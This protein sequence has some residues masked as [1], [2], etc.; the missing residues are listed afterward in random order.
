MRIVNTSN[1]D[2]TAKIC[3][4]IRRRYNNMPVIPAT[5]P[6]PAAPAVPRPIDVMNNFNLD[7][8]RDPTY[9]PSDDFYDQ[10]DDVASRI[11]V[12]TDGPIGYTL[13]GMRID[14]TLARSFLDNKIRTDEMDHDPTLAE[15]PNRIMQG[16]VLEGALNN[17]IDG[18]NTGS[19]IP[20]GFRL[21]AKGVKKL[22]SLAMSG[23][24][25]AARKTGEAGR[26]VKQTVVEKAEIAADISDVLID[27]A[28]ISARAAKHAVKQSVA[29]KS[30][31]AADISN[32]VV[33]ETRETSRLASERTIAA[34]ARA[35][36]A[37][38]D[39]ALAARDK[40]FEIAGSPKRWTKKQYVEVGAFVT[41]LHT[42]IPEILDELKETKKRSVAYYNFPFN[43]NP[44]HTEDNLRDATKRGVQRAAINLAALKQIKDAVK[45]SWKNR[46][47]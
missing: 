35:R 45:D 23:V 19:R 41:A 21:G 29:N 28:G 25:I 46:K 38:T 15:A 6:T 1:I 7:R 47:A 18:Y 37:A 12:T 16:D 42:E 4:D 34:M 20:E 39:K 31:I 43:R 9:F 27:E 14:S 32:A 3:Y 26:A 17:F 36:E 13:D 2:K 44:R 10:I 24:E 30:E 33:D 5:P 40:T 11:E 22:G 8:E